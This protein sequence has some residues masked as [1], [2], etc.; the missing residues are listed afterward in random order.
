M[1]ILKLILAIL[2][3]NSYLAIGQILEPGDG[4]RISFYNIND[5]VAGDFFIEKDGNV[6]LPYIGFVNTVDKEFEEVRTKVIDSYTK[7]YKEP[8]INI[9]PLLRVHIIG[10]VSNPGV[11]YLTGVEKLSDLIALTGG[12]KSYS[13]IDHIVL[14]R[15]GQA[16]QIDIEAFLEGDENLSNIGIESGDEIYIPKTWWEGAGKVSIIVSGVAVIV[17]IA[18]LLTN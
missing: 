3:F 6:H 7:L 1:R 17:A 8:E 12:E 14:I 11:Y 9:I 15:D 4:I 10:E 13:D 2:L 16:L 5:P 18:G